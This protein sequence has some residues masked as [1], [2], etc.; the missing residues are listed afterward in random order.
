MISNKVLWFWEDLREI[1]SH[2]RQSCSLLKVFPARQC[3]QQ[4]TFRGNPSYNVPRM[5]Q[6][7]FQANQTKK[8]RHRGD[9]N[10]LSIAYKHE[11]LANQATLSRYRTRIW[12]IYMNPIWTELVGES[13]KV[14][15]FA[16]MMCCTINIH[17][18][19]F[20]SHRQISYWVEI[21]IKK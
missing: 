14:S 20:N 4:L 8:D 3:R 21:S 2:F 10:T 1:Q 18:K 16:L 12:N 7:K 5:I 13:E 17:Y 11:A 6:A 9:S 15:G 19:H